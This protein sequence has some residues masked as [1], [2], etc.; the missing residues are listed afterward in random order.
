MDLKLQQ[1]NLS[2]YSDINFK[3]KILKS[4]KINKNIN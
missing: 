1:F 4:D 2:F 3:L